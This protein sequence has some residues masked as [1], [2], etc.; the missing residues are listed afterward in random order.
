MILR[1]AVLSESRLVLD[2][3]RADRL[4]V[5]PSRSTAT[6]RDK[7]PEPVVVERLVPTPITF[8][9]VV[10]WLQKGDARERLAEHLA[11]DLD[12]LRSAA[13]AEGLAAGKAKGLEEAEAHMRSALTALEAL[14][15]QTELALQA[16]TDE[17]S[18]HCAEV[19]CEALT[20]IAG[21]ILSMR[22]AAL[23]S[24]LEVLKRVKDER[25]LTIRVSAHDLPALREWRDQ[26]ETACGGRKLELVADAK[27]VAGGCIV[28]SALGG[29]DGRIDVQLRGLADTL[30]AA[31]AVPAEIP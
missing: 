17:L 14:V 26:I 11:D 31:K 10:E 29:L 15:V 7:A 9:A 23:G 8:D 28:E 18:A 3:A 13:R 20:R 22:E 27:V 6:T 30:R 25:E 5:E 19:V 21:P 24:V 16:E 12:E 1:G 2:A 4:A